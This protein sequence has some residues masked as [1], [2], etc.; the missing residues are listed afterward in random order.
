ME[1]DL[2][3]TSVRYCHQLALRTE[4]NSLRSGLVL[5]PVLMVSFSDR[6]Q[7]HLHLWPTNQCR[8]EP[9][10]DIWRLKHTKRTTAQQQVWFGVVNFSLSP[11]ENT[12]C[13][14]IKHICVCLCAC[15]R[16]CVHVCVHVRV[17][18]HACMHAWVLA[19]ACMHAWVGACACVCVHA[20]VHVCVVEGWV[21]GWHLTVWKVPYSQRPWFGEI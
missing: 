15:V 9:E 7:P 5:A 18:V 21:Y 16:A 11:I 10:V 13:W 1:S 14:I 17:C 20:C 6:P 8:Y 3:K 2:L 12:L 4:L 19:C